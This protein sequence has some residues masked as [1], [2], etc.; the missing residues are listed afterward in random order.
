MTEDENAKIGILR[1][2]SVIESEREV[3][4]EFKVVEGEERSQ[5]HRSIADAS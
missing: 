3:V 4:L 2:L 1:E 5:S